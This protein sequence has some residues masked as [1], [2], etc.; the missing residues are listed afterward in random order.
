MNKHSR[1]SFYQMNITYILKLFKVLL[2]QKTSEILHDAYLPY[3]KN[4]GGQIAKCP[5]HLIFTDTL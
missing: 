4:K 5:L 2:Y 3:I 1:I